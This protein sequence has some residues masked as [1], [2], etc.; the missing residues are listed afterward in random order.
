MKKTKKRSYGSVEMRKRTSEER[1]IAARGP[2][3]EYKLIRIPTDRGTNEHS[4]KEKAEK[5]IRSFGYKKPDA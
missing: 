4:K 1:E 3:K 2:S 5:K